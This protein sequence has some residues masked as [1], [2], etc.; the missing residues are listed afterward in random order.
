[1]VSS[2]VKGGA[3]AAQGHS[4]ASE[5][6]LS[7]KPHKLSETSRRNVAIPSASFLYTVSSLT[8]SWKAARG[9]GYLLSGAGRACRRVR[10]AKSLDRQHS[11]LWPVVLLPGHILLFTNVSCHSGWL[12]HN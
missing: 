11:A 7:C 8:T 12:L 3:A 10:E 5:F 6:G 1:M 9:A 4:S 2:G